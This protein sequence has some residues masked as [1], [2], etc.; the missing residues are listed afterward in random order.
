MRSVFLEGILSEE[1]A[2]R[3]LSA[4]FADQR[5]HATK[6]VFSPDRQSSIGW[7]YVV[8]PDDP[9][10]QSGPYMIMADYSGRHWDF[11]AKSIVVGALRRV[12]ARIGGELRDYD[13]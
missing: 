13:C 12:Q 9:D 5:E 10:E 1:E 8:Q 7:L 4:E 3:G 2:H 11:D 6:V